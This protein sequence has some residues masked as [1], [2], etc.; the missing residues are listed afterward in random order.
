[1]KFEVVGK[2]IK[3]GKCK[4]LFRKED[5]EFKNNK[6]L[7]EEELKNYVPDSEEESEEDIDDESDQDEKEDDASD[8]EE[9]ERKTV[10]KLGNFKEDEEDF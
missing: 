7:F 4:K 10:K 6:E 8:E 1:M 5:K 2:K 3:E 9:T